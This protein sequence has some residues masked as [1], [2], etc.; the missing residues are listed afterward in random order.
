VIP[1]SLP[2]LR[3]RPGDVRELA[4]HFLRLYAAPG[5]SPR[6]TEEFLHQLESHSWPGN[7]R[8]LANC[9]RRAVAMAS[10]P[11]IGAAEFDGSDWITAAAPLPPLS[12]SPDFM[13]GPA[14]ISNLNNA[15]LRPGVSLGEMERKLFEMTLEATKGNRSRAAELLGVSLRTVRNKVRSYGLPNWSSY[16]HD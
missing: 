9:V 7:V 5:A 3:E 13:V 6:L 10:G 14:T 8:E 4:E 11:E 12:M 15:Q 2:P 1:L 16:V